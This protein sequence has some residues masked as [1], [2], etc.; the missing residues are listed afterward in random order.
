M[1]I[2]T[3]IQSTDQYIQKSNLTNKQQTTYQKVL[4][5]ITTVNREI[6]IR[7]WQ[8]EIYLTYV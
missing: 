2:F 5:Y 3:Y 6:G 7:L 1:Y 4:Y 8:C